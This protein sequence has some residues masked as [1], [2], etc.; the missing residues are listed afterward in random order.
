MSDIYHN[1]ILAFVAAAK[2]AQ[3]QRESKFINFCYKIFWYNESRTLW[4]NESHS[5]SNVVINQ[6]K[7]RSYTMIIDKFYNNERL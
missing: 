5:M 3:A 1:T 7:L 6:I 2:I 4:H